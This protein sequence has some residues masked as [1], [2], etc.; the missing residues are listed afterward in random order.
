MRKYLFVVN[1]KAGKGRGEKILPQLKEILSAKNID[2]EIF[3]TTKKGDARDIAHHSREKDIVLVS[4][5]GDGTV[6]E[7]INGLEDK[8][9]L[10]LSVLPIGSG[11]DFARSLNLIGEWAKVLE[12]IISK[13][14]YVIID[15]GKVKIWDKGSDAPVSSYFINSC[16]IGFDAYV[17]FFG[18]QNKVLRGLPLYLYS[19]LKALKLYRASHIT[20]NFDNVKIDGKKLLI[21]IGN[22]QTA[23]GGFKLTPNAIMDDSLL[24]A[25]IADNLSKKQILTVLPKAINGSHINLDVIQ[26]EKFV[27]A[28][29]YLAEPNYVHVDG[30]IISSNAEKIN[31]VINGRK[32]KVLNGY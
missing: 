11:N 32:V 24:D 18:N 17:A 27:E 4:V 31:V 15:V 14:N 30:E 8:S 20:G 13:E 16:G 2:V 29:L 21:A 9:N 3:V 23:G 7:V 1:P 22:G 12:I 5:G 10:I 19:V 28:N 6:N 26:Y 25:C